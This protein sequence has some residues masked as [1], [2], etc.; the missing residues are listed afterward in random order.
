MTSSYRHCL[1]IVA[2]IVLVAASAEAQQI[3]GTFDQLRVL[4]KPGDTLTITD[5]S[6]ARV[7]GKL[8][9]LS[10]SS[11]RLNVSGAQR[12][13]QESNIDTISQRRPDSLR[14]G[15]LTGLA[16]GG[17]L[18]GLF[19][20]AMIAA[21]DGGAAGW[22]VAGALFYAGIG[23]GIGTGIDALIEGRQVIYAGSSSKRTTVNI[24]PIVRGRRKGLLFSVNLTR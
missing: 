17:G 24:S 15:A 11:L 1:R 7:Q 18:G 5:G 4:V 12:E 19:I 21:D 10:G 22:A 16:V 9:E 20:A 14:N 13:F 3:A 2:L 6:G 23:A 8:S